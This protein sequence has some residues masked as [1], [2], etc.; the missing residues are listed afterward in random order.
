DLW[1]VFK[2]PVRIRGLRLAST[3]GPAAFD[4]V[5]LGRTEKDLAAAKPDRQGAGPP[6]PGGHRQARHDLHGDPLPAGAL[7]R[8]GT[9]RFRHGQHI[10]VIAFS[11]DGKAIASAG[12]DGKIVL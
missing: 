5:L 12:R 3:G 1:E 9:V 4:Q 10:A 2:K 6:K 8:L 7:A 11:P